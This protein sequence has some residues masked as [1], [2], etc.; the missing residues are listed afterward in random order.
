MIYTI[1]QLNL[2]FT[3]P[4]DR[5][6]NGIAFQHDCLQYNHNSKE[7]VYYCLSEQSI[8]SNIKENN[9]FS[10]YTFAEL[11]KMNVTSEQLYLWS[12]PVDLIEHYQFYLN[13]Q[14]T[15]T[16][17]ENLLLS[18]KY[19]YNCTLPRF[20]PECRYEY[21]FLDDN[22]LPIYD[23]NQIIDHL[24]ELQISNLTCYIHLSC[25]RGYGMGCLDWSEVCDGH[26]NCLHNAIDEEHCWQ[27]ELNQCKDNE[28]RCHNGQCVP[29][30]YYQTYG[31]L[32]CLDQSDKHKKYDRSSLFYIGDYAFKY[33]TCTITFLTSSCLKSRHIFLMKTLLSIKDDQIS[34]DCSTAFYCSLNL[35]ADNCK[36]SKNLEVNVQ[37]VDKICPNAIKLSSIPILFGDIYIMYIKNVSQNITEEK[38]W[39][40]YLCTNNS[41]YEKYFHNRPKIL[42]NTTQCYYYTIWHLDEQ[43]QQDELTLF[44]YQNEILYQNILLINDSVELCQ[45]SNI[46]KC[47]NSSKC[48]SIYRLL[49]FIQDC[50]YGDDEDNIRFES[51]ILQELF[52]RRTL[53]CPMNNK[54][55]VLIW[56]F[57]PVQCSCV[58]IQDEIC[59]EDKKY[60]SHLDWKVIPFEMTCNGLIDTIDSEFTDETECEQWPCN[61]LYTHCDGLWNCPNGIDELNCDIHLP[62]NCSLNEHICVSSLT[63]QLICL[64]LNKINDNKIDCLGGIDEQKICRRNNSLTKYNNFRCINDQ[65]KPCIDATHICDGQKNCLHGDDEQFCQETHQIESWVDICPS[66]V[67]SN[68]FDI[69]HFICRSLE[70]SKFKSPR[71]FTLQTQIQSRSSRILT[72]NNF[73]HRCHYG[74]DIKIWTNNR[75]KR[76]CLCP[77]DHYGD[78]CQYQNQAVNL[79]LTFTAPTN[80][81]RIPFAIIISLIDDDHARIIHSYH[82]FTTYPPTQC[83]SIHNIDLTYSIRPKNLTK[84]Y[85][86]HIDIYEKLSLAYRASF[87]FPIKYSFL[88]VYRL[89]YDIYIPSHDYT[90]ICSDKRCIHGKC[91][92]YFNHPEKAT[93]CQCDYGWS[94]KYCH[95]PHQCICSSDSICIGVSTSNRSVCV[96]PVN[97]YGPRCFLS[98][99]I[100]QTKESICQNGGQCI[101]IVDSM[102]NNKNRFICRCPIGFSG[103]RCEE[104][105][106]KLILSFKKD[107]TV[108]Q[109]LSVHMIFINSHIGIIRTTI[110]EMIPVNQKI[111]TIELIYEFHILLIEFIKHKY[112]L[113]SVDKNYNATEP[114]SKTIN[115][116]DR[117][118]HITEL[119]NQ[120]ILTYPRIRR[121]KY[122][123]L[124]CQTYR[125]DLTCFYDDIYICLCYD[126]DQQRLANCFIFD[127]EMKFQ[128]YQQSQCENDGQCFSY[129]YR[130]PEK[131]TCIC[132][133]CFYGARCQFQ[134]NGFDF[135]LDGILGYHIQPQIALISQSVLVQTSAVLNVIFIILILINAISTMITFT[136]K[137]VHEVGCGYYLFGLAINTLLIMI[138][139]ALKYWIFL[140]IQM[141]IITNRT[142]I[143]YQ[144]R[145]IDFLLR[146]FLYVDQ[147]LNSSVAIERAVTTIKGISFNKKKSRQAVKFVIPVIFLIS[148]ISNI[149]DPIH[150]RLIN[151]EN[152][153]GTRIWCI[154][155]YSS[156]LQTYNSIIHI[157]HFFA[158][159]LINIISSF[160]LIT[161]KSRQTHTV[162]TKEN[163]RNILK[164]Q[165]LER[166]HLFMAPAI[167]ILLAIPRLIIAFTSKCSYSI[168]DAWLYLSGYFLSFLSPMITF[169]IVVMPS[170]IYKNEFRKT[171]RR[172]RNQIQRRFAFR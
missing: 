94:G 55:Y 109:T 19:F 80:I 132:P 24:N 56:G 130:C 159:F 145:S 46:Y 58:S 129:N 32:G 160:I 111:V 146:T 26:V 88:P 62:L 42:L 9:N 99:T 67:T 47:Q 48:I 150:R 133:Q 148:M 71:R 27:M 115:S 169:V 45:R 14:L 89:T 85:S 171:V 122:Y 63:N 90:I 168:E 81:H 68:V 116:K 82:Q 131:Q 22:N 64:P 138:A 38:Y 91:I 1:P 34:Y 134:T 51:P 119:F 25:D 117:C 72:S 151:E 37:Y 20:G 4:V 60:L 18:N 43:V 35:F 107:I 54:K 17:E 100:C 16:I 104:T 30:H 21:D 65:I 121:I 149:H 74:I 57:R 87:L 103:N 162:Q 6:E 142:F 112:Y 157:I 41:I 79:I 136:G 172:Y 141:S 50:P 161:I 36:N 70:I 23:I 118:R 83:Y 93:F 152:Y 66:L 31:T 53:K 120:T 59:D 97:R 3:D 40:F 84:N 106:K 78:V 163:Y 61:N 2:H 102:G 44:G 139:F 124:P 86:I 164:K 13:Q 127:H 12:A 143:L 144:C 15:T 128:C 101:S 154:V 108:S 98:D 155:R 29:W 28:Y 165:I 11:S 77:S 39:N 49:D 140:L 5:S 73:Y 52:K 69:D 113:I 10:K 110:I 105:K 123:Q 76:S 147:L 95:I 92:R 126:Y 7:S 166:K 170:K 125:P 156:R 167:L 114:L 33:V 96:C 8:N 137:N 158:P 75:T 135:S 153:K